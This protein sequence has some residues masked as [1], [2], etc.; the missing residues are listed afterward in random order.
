MIITQANEGTQR[1]H[2]V[3]NLKKVW[4][5]FLL[6]AFSLLFF[7]LAPTY[8]NAMGVNVK[9]TAS[10]QVDVQ[11][12]M[13]NHTVQIGYAC[14]RERMEG[15]EIEE[16]ALVIINDTLKLSPKQPE[17]WVLLQNFSLGFPYEYGFNLE[18]CFAYDASN[19]D[20]LLPQ[21]QLDVG[22]GRIGF[23][24]VNV[25]FPEP[26]VNITDREPY[27]LT[28]VF[29][30]SNLIYAIT[31]TSF[32]VDFPMYPSLAQKASVCNVTVILPRHANCTDSTFH[33]KGLHFDITHLDHS[34]ALKHAKIDLDSFQYEPA[35]LTFELTGEVFPIVDVE[36]KREIKLDQW[37]G[38]HVS[39]FYHIT[40]K[41][42]RIL[43][44]IS[45]YFPQGV[46]H[47]TAR[48]EIGPLDLNL[49]ELAMA[50]IGYSFRY[51]LETNQ[52]GEFTITYRLPWKKYVNQYD[53]GSYNLALTSLK[54]FDWMIRKLTVTI[55][56][57]EGAEFQSSARAPDS[58]E[59]SAFQET[60]TFTFYNITPFHDLDFD[61]TYGYLAFWAS[62][63]P[64]LW[65]GV[66]AIIVCALALLWRAPK[67]PPVPIVPVPP[68][69]LRSF[70]DAYERKTG[71]LLELESMEE[72]LRKGRISRRRYKV[73]KKMLEGRLSTLS[74]DLTDLRE[75]IRAAGAKYADTMRQIEVAETML[76]GVETDIRRV[77][78]RYRRGEISKGAYRR[79]LGEYLRRRERAKTT[80]DG[81]LLRLREEIR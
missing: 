54:P 47:P 22:L 59:K 25:I 31:S 55:T 58:V 37:G 2:V 46:S 41:A 19:P 79:L 65:M 13:V 56:L 7:A 12:D 48:D 10:S 70:I 52:A 63:R 50:I 74:R 67:P 4:M 42:E 30:F 3:F 26:G 40:N 66:L 21:P 24:G 38:I 36:I 72:W 45:I 32:H 9:A 64:T 27:D 18:Y 61:L 28:V 68:E 78:A 29:V 62:F 51:P 44:S 43:T 20:E 49:R 77:E 76:E 39:D 75:K 73:R 5:T 16:G 80:I 57:P 8:V 34:D 23:Y 71:I 35:W 60:V 69:D 1:T 11:V 15:A 14:A 17:T 33:E 81:F 53:L 6:L